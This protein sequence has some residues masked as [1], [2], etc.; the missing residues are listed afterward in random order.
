MR[1]TAKKLR[2]SIEVLNFF[3][4]SDRLGISSRFSVFITKCD[5]SHL[6]LIT[7]LG[8][9]LCRLDDIQLLAK[10]MVCNSC[11]IDNIQCLAL[12]SYSEPDCNFR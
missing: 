7:P 2:T 8:V 12:I 10:L 6:Y 1:H 5:K 9:Y 11:G 3:I 4:Q